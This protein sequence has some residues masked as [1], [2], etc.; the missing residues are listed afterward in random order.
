MQVAD[1]AILPAADLEEPDIDHYYSV[2]TSVFELI[3][4]GLS[5]GK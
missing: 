5:L 4:L 3:L 2:S 1:R